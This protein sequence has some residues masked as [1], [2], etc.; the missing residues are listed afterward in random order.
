MTCLGALLDVLDFFGFRLILIDL[1]EFQITVR[2]F[3][4][5]RQPTADYAYDTGVVPLYQQ[6]LDAEVPEADDLMTY[7]GARCH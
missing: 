3:G 2:G 7:P 1:G 5:E 6:S 4:A